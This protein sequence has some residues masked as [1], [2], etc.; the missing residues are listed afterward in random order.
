MMKLDVV[1]N[2]KSNMNNPIWNVYCQNSLQQW[3]FSSYTIV[4]DESTSFFSVI[5]VKYDN[6][7]IVIG[8][9]WKCSQDKG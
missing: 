2:C 6:E 5:V 3:F 4:Y 7:V 1:F 9:Y 8:I